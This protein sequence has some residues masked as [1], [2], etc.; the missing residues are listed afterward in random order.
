MIWC[1]KLCNHSKSLTTHSPR[2]INVICEPPLKQILIIDAAESLLEIPCLYYK[3]KHVSLTFFLVSVT[4]EPTC[5]PSAFW[6]YEHTA[7]FWHMVIRCAIAKVVAAFLGQTIKSLG[8]E[9]QK[10]NTVV[11]NWVFSVKNPRQFLEFSKKD[12]E[13]KKQMKSD[14]ILLKI[15]FKMLQELR[16]KILIFSLFF[17][18]LV[19]VF[20][21]N[22]KSLHL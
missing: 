18:K 8:E 15:S 21:R 14:N 12:L 6:V 2:P 1:H 9:A 22:F 10:P 17:E 4:H 7:C 3:A 19:V 20:L 11:V 13:Y 5:L 16:K